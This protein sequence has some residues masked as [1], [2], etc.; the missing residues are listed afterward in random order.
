M[1]LIFVIWVG[2]AFACRK[3]AE[4][5]G[6]GAGAWTVVGLLF[7]IPAL[8]VIALLP[9]RMPSTVRNA[10]SFPQSTFSSPPTFKES[11]ELQNDQRDDGDFNPPKFG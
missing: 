9:T 10:P 5:K 4:S 7:G 3:I 8:I 2:C 6:R 11:P 1:F